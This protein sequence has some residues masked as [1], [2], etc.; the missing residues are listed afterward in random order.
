MNDSLTSLLERNIDLIMEAFNLDAQGNLIAAN[1]KKVAEADEI[2]HQYFVKRMNQAF[3][4]INENDPILG[5]EPNMHPMGTDHGMHG[6]GMPHGMRMGVE[7]DE[8]QQEFGDEDMG[9]MAMDDMHQGQMGPAQGSSGMAVGGGGMAAPAMESD[10]GG[11]FDW[12]FNEDTDFEVDSLFGNLSEEDDEEE[13]EDDEHLNEFMDDDMMNGSAGGDDFLPTGGMDHDGG[14]NDFGGDMGGAD[15]GDDM[16]GD[17]DMMTIHGQMDNGGEFEFSFDKDAIGFDDDMGGDMG[18]MGDMHHEEHEPHHEE[19]GMGMGEEEN[20]NPMG[21]S[22]GEG[23]PGFHNGKPAKGRKGGKTSRM[24]VVPDN[25]AVSHAAPFP[26]PQ[27]S[28]QK[29]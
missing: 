17:D 7:G 12:V 18:G 9:N 3:R 13:T 29:R 8:F 11:E 2:F 14:A 26:T 1:K 5:M 24:A 25:P 22:A 23:L 19:P 27:G 16:E 21:E 6:M 20:H 15:M 28:K 10:E 4:Q